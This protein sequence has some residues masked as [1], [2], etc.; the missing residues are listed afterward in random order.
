MS[1]GYS[2]TAGFLTLARQRVFPGV[3]PSDVLLRCTQK[4]NTVA[5]TA[6]ASHRIPSLPHPL[7]EARVSPFALQRYNKMREQQKIWQ[8]SFLSDNLTCEVGRLNVAN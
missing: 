6:P 1:V 8:V 3:S 4:A 7:A 2:E 5:G